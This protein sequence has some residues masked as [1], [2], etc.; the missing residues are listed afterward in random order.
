VRAA[1]LRPRFRRAKEALRGQRFHFGIQGAG[2]GRVRVK[3]RNSLLQ[4]GQDARDERELF[5]RYEAV[6]FVAPSAS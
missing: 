4:P 3:V 2:V 1:N 5:F 6:H